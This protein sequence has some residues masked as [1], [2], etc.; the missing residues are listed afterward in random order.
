MTSYTAKCKLR[1]EYESGI[2]QQQLIPHQ[3]NTH[4][5]LE[6]EICALL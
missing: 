5:N 3:N 4:R 1:P 2:I 6:H